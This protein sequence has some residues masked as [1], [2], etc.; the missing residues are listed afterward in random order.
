MTVTMLFL[1]RWP[2]CLVLV[3]LA[4]NF[5]GKVRG[6]TCGAYRG[7]RTVEK[8]KFSLPENVVPDP[9]SV[10][11]GLLQKGAVQRV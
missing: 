8:A 6:M 5:I 3:G 1:M 7:T 11:F 10:W 2:E 9:R 4:L